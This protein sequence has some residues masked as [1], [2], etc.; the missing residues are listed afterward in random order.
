MSYFLFVIA[1]LMIFINSKSNS[2]KEEVFSSIDGIVIKGFFSIIIIIH[3]IGQKIDV[4][5]FN[6]SNELIGSFAVGVFFMISAYGMLKSCKK[7]DYNYIKELIL[8]KIPKLYAIQ[9]V[10]NLIYYFI[11]YNSGLT[12]EM[13]LRIFNLHLLFGLNPLNGYSWF[14]T[15]IICIYVIFALTLIIAKLFKLSNKELFLCITMIIFTGLLY[16]YVKYLAKNISIPKLYI[17]AIVCYALGVI[18]YL[19]ENWVI[20]IPKKQNIILIIITFI[21]AFLCFVTKIVSSYMIHTQIMPALLCIML[22][23]ICKNFSFENNKIGIF[24]GK[25]SLFTYLLQKIVFNLI[26]IQFG[27]IFYGFIIIALTIIVATIATLLLRGIEKIIKK[28]KQL[29]NK[30]PDEIT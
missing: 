25:I 18:V 3:H 16:C 13:I 14:I 21:A 26:P 11:F 22:V 23:L 27:G 4:F 1:L 19:F 9:V 5:S 28:I 10:V 12:Q 20:S 24:L 29:F 8:R 17:R 2:H 7:K 15:T 6:Y 30:K